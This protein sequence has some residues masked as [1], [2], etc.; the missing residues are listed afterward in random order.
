MNNCF[1]IQIYIIHNHSNVFFYFIL[2][3]VS[4]NFSPLARKLFAICIEKVFGCT[5]LLLDDILVIGN[6]LNTINNN[7]FI[8]QKCPTSFKNHKLTSTS[9]T[10]DRQQGREVGSK[11]KAQTCLISFLCHLHEREVREFFSLFIVV[12][13]LVEFMD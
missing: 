5:Y 1:F 11:C 10:T 3:Q 8:R 6:I 7:K 13:L 12:N 2:W 9:N 4:H